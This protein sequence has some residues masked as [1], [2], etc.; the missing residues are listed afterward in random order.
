[1][2]LSLPSYILLLLS[3]LAAATGCGGASHPHSRHQV[4]LPPVAGLGGDFVWRQRIVARH[5]KGDMSFGSV[6]E[7][8]GNH[9]TLLGLTPFGTRA[10]LLE[11][12]G[13][14]FHFR[15][16]M[17]Q[18]LPFPPEYILTDVHRVFH[19]SASEPQGWHCRLHTKVRT[20]DYW[21]GSRLLKR[22]L[23]HNTS[24]KRAFVTISYGEGYVSH[25]PPRHI[26]LVNH[27]YGYS[28]D[29]TTLVYS[30]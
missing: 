26:T 15:T 11:Q 3:C 29:I 4:S 19:L 21:H 16:F 27:E 20:C 5:A 8:R 17:P 28:L 23:F 2:T 24:P 14:R 30:H 6:L 1:M 9:L 18:R 25:R 22:A 12:D 13:A 10:F 7:K